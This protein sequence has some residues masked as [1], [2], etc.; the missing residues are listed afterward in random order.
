MGGRGGWERGGEEKG[1][2]VVFGGGRGGGG[3]GVVGGLRS[4][5]RGRRGSVVEAETGGE[6]EEA[7]GV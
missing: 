6:V 3:E 5:M 7:V 2:V 4:V 1:I